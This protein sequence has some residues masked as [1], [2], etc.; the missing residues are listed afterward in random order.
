MECDCESG[1]DF[2]LL[3]KQLCPSA[4]LVCIRLLPEQEICDLTAG[5]VGGS[6]CSTIKGLSSMIAVS[7]MI[8]V[9]ILIHFERSIKKLL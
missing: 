6:R 9:R 2:G 5:D 7:L 8:I 3:I 1:R 4:F